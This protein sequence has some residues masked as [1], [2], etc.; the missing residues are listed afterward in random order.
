MTKYI[1]ISIAGV[2]ARPQRHRRREGGEAH[3]EAAPA[4]RLL[5]AARH[6]QEDQQR[7]D[8]RQEGDDGQQADRRQA[9]LFMWGAPRWPPSLFKRRG[10]RPPRTPPADA[11][12]A[13]GNPWR[14][15]IIRVLIAPGSTPRR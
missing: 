14:S 6:Q 9:H 10:L 8:R 7:A 5:V 1:G 13:P 3:D 11:R 4:Q 15:S 12:S 2:E